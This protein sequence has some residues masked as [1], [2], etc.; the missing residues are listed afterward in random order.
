MMM[1]LLLLLLLLLLLF[2][3]PAGVASGP[4]SHVL[5][6]AIMRRVCAL[7][8]EV[9]DIAAASLRVRACAAGNNGV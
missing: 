7:G 2:A 9:L 6:I 8:R 5:Q 4:R 3:A 1:I